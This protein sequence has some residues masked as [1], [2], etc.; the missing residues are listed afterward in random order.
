MKRKH[1]SKTEGYTW[2]EYSFT[3]FNG[4]GYADRKSPEA[5]VESYIAYNRWKKRS[6]GVE[7]AQMYYQPLLTL[8]EY[9]IENSSGGDRIPSEEKMIQFKQSKLDI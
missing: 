9:L 8:A 4:S 6:K 3:A 2:L 1:H 7:L 5:F